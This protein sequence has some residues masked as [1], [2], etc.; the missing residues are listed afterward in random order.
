M[1]DEEWVPDV[2]KNPEA[3]IA[4]IQSRIKKAR[5]VDLFTFAQKLPCVE[6]LYSYLFEY[7]SKAAVRINSFAEWWVSLPQ[8]TRKNVRRSERR[9]VTVNIGGLHDAV[10][11]GIQAVNNACPLV[12]GKK[13]RYY[14]R[15]LEQTRKDQSSYLDR[16]VFLCAYHEA[17]MIGYLKLV[18]CNGYA[19]IMGFLSN[20]AHQA[21]RPANTLLARAVQLCADEGIPY[22][23]YGMLNYGNKSDGSLR[24]FKLRNGFREVRLPRYYI[25]LT[26]RGVI[27]LRLKL[28]RGLLGILP[29]R[30]I[31]IL[32]NFRSSFYK[33]KLSRACE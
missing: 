24:E 15:S 26:F 23:V 22:L 10:V 2:V 13:S 8:E 1:H 14:G 4:S 5:P 3:W 9:G 19:T 29:S 32:V 20:P 28:H 25:P 11:A 7:D 6:P 31:S 21:K 30:L 12:Q 18:R 33:F 27:A 17:E 16:S